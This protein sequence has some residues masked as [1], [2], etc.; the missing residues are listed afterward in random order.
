MEAVPRPK[1]FAPPGLRSGVYKHAEAPCTFREDW[2]APTPARADGSLLFCLHTVDL[3][4]EL[5]SLLN[6]G[7]LDLDATESEIADWQLEAEAEATRAANAD[8]ASL[9]AEQ[10]VT[11]AYLTG[12]TTTGRKVGLVVPHRPFYFVKVPAD[13]GEAGFAQAL[14]DLVYKLKVGA[15]DVTAT[16][17]RRPGFLGYE[18]D[19]DNPTTRLQ[20]L[21]ARVTFSNMA[22]AREA[23][24][25]FEWG[26]R[27]SG[28]KEELRVT[29]FEVAEARIEPEQMFIDCYDLTPSG[30]HVAGAIA[31]V[32]EEGFSPGSGAP[33]GMPR[34]R[35]MLVDEEYH[36][37]RANCIRAVT[38][39]P[40]AAAMPPLCVASIDG[41]MFSAAPGRMPMATRA[42]DRVIVMGI[43][44]AFA[45]AVGSRP[46][47]GGD[48]A[49]A[50]SGG[51]PELS[52]GV[53]FERLAFVLADHCEPIPGVVVHLFDS[54]M[55]LIT[56][57]REELFV[58]KKVDVVL[59]HNITKFDIK[60]LAQRVLHFA[61]P[62]AK[63]FLRFG[64]LPREVVELRCKP[65]NSPALGSN[66][67]WLLNGAG[68]VYLDTL[69]LC[70]QNHKLRENSL[71]CA[72]AKFLAAADINKFEMPY[73][74]ISTA[75]R[76]GPEDV[77]KLTAYCVQD[78][79]VPLCLAK[80]WAS[81][82]DNVAQAR[83]INIPMAVNVKV[84]QQQRVRNTLMKHNN[85]NLL[86]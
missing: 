4:D 17:E 51:N 59:G 63:G 75:I 9:L 32:P 57:V 72:A 56:A 18:P 83:V 41:E 70:K 60:Y 58:R 37:L 16:F 23:S 3:R 81:V 36:V 1:A 73:E 49:E 35:T 8:G 24:R 25:R 52:E 2:T 46:G 27:V 34:F 55:E 13:V 38:K 67:L 74:L 66:M 86:N 19:P 47:A 39:G 5:L 43:V 15:H 76:G 85:L 64:C 20:H 53:E 42:S 21:Y 31:R 12:Q 22:L 71:K 29:K 54:E 62:E 10:P 26:L 68:F 78:C 28:Y 48:E 7:R 65:L 69:L 50:G 11:L 61:A 77:M 30:W 80:V 40:E 14:R 45:G 6:H 79:V 44:F 84:G 33:P 82:K